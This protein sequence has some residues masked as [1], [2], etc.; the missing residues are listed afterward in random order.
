MEFDPWNASAYVTAVTAR[1]WSKFQ[2]TL[3]FEL[4][5][6]SSSSI[7]RQVNGPVVDDAQPDS[8]D[9]SSEFVCRRLSDFLLNARG[10]NFDSTDS[11]AVSLKQ[12]LFKVTVTMHACCRAKA[13]NQICQSR[14]CQQQCLLRRNYYH[15]CLSEQ[16]VDERFAVSYFTNFSRTASRRRR[17]RPTKWVQVSFPR[18]RARLAAAFHVYAWTRTC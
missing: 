8:T 17:R 7:T 6:V 12:A 16:M 4:S 18:S 11:I 10:K 15:G 14:C 5:S 3:T 2:L 13:R 1:K 9:T